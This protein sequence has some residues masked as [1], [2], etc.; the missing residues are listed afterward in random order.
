M[1]MKITQCDICKKEIEKDAEKLQI[2]REG[3]LLFKHFEICAD[4]GK[5]VLKF[6][7]NK[8]LIKEETK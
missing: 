8:K 5:P 3:R 4:C 7:K 1:V 6:L 2:A